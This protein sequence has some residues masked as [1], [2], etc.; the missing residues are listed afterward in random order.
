MS[1]VFI[2][3]FWAG[4]GV[5]DPIEVDQVSLYTITGQSQ[6]LMSTNSVNIY[7]ISGQNAAEMQIDQV[8]VYAIVEI[9]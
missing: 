8:N 5:G 3:S 7:V 6:L 1:V 4:G 2:N 9:P